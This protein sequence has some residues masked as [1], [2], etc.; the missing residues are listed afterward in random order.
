MS[1]TSPLGN[2]QRQPPARLRHERTLYAIACSHVASSILW[3]GLAGCG[4]HSGLSTDLNSKSGNHTDAPDTAVSKRT[5]AKDHPVQG[6]IYFTAVDDCG[7]DFRH[8]S[9]TSAEK[10]F[11]A[12]N[13]SGVAALDYDL[14][15]RYDLYFATGTPFPIDP[16]RDSPRNR[17]YRNLG[18]WRFEDVTELCGLGH[19]GYSAGLA[20]GDYDSDGFPDVYVNCYGS[21]CLYR[22]QGDGTF[23]K[24]DS[25]SGAADE[26]WGTSAAMFDANGDGMLDIYVCNYAVWSMETNEWCGDRE[27]NVRI[28]CS[29]RSVPP[30]QD[31]LLLNLGDGTF[32]DVAEPAGLTA[33]PGRGQGVVAADINDD[34]L[35]D[36]YVGND[37]HPNALFINE[38]KSHDTVRFRDVSEASGAA[39]D[40]RGESQAGMGVD[41]AD[42]NRDGRIDLL[43]TNFEREHNAYYENTGNA[44]FADVSLVSGLGADSMPWVGWGTTFADFDLD[45]WPDVIVTNGHVDDNLHLLGRDAPYA[46]P[47]Q[48]WRNVA[49]RFAATGDSAGE[50]F[51]KPHSG[52]A[53]AIV[54]LDNDGDTDVVIGHQ[55][56]VPALLRNERLSNS[57]SVKETSRRSVRLK[58]VG[59]K[60][61]RD[62]I[63]ATVML[64]TGDQSLMQQVKGGG[65]YL[66][67]HDQRLVF[68]LDADVT[69]INGTIRWPSGVVSSLVELQRGT[70]YLVI[71]PSESAQPPVVAIIEDIQ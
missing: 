52:R 7:I 36:L 22:N 63:G 42:V 18:N 3:M 10:P 66:S 55:D 31:G 16:S 48:L 62:A 23:E 32:L 25:T 5:T 56:E 2:Q 65:S 6:T 35:T 26:R 71:E 57:R 46:Q 29:P 49:G 43:V 14:D 11:P 37:L 45:G 41:A 9:G 68:A 1:S 15:G 58:L 17:M 34:G 67:A 54:D 50:Y 69:S 13:G 33:R 47:P 20:V 70:S 64:D 51:R 39:Y 12:A 60:S 19:N 24:I 8:V 30:E 44:I 40:Y 21:N 28:F 27:R 38:T 53:L 61:N 59:T 4:F